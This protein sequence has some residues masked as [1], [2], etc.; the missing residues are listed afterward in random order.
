MNNEYFTFGV[1]T[2]NQEEWVV[3]CLNSIKYQINNYGREYH[4]K[5][6]IVDDASKDSTVMVIDQWL[7]NYGSIFDNIIFNKNTNNLGTVKNYQ[8]IISLIGDENFK[9]IAGDD[10]FSSRNLFLAYTDI[11]R[12]TIISGYRV[13]LKNGNVYTDSTYGAEFYHKMTK[14]RDHR[15]D[16]KH[17]MRGG[18]LHTP[19]TI[20]S[21]ELYIN[22]GAERL[23]CQ[24]RLFEDD[25]TWYSMIKNTPNVQ[26]IFKPEIYVLYRIS[27]KSV[28]NNGDATHVAKEFSNELQKLHEIYE[29][30]SKGWQKIYQRSRLKQGNKFLS[31]YRYVNKADT[32]YLNLLKLFSPKFKKFYRE[33]ER[34]TSRE[35]EYYISTIKKNNI[36]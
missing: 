22:S 17:I 11:D 26:I 12:R 18:Y 16:L 13:L 34:E 14:H 27:N 29:K 5:L 6:I 4:C 15:Y 31:W 28:S 2:Y 7:N 33:I 1:L 36:G 25:P 10:V 23:N 24:F 32:I 30:A 21:K 19:S 35:Q 3:E 8:K 9:V 20:Y